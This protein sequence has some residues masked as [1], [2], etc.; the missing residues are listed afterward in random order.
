[1]YALGATLIHLLTGTS[2]ADLPQKDS[3]IQFND[4]VSLK[5]SF[6]SWIETMTEI[7]LEKRYS[8]ARQA[9]EALQ[10]GQMRPSS[11]AK[12]PTLRKFSKPSGTYIKLDKSAEQL[13]IIIPAPG[14]KILA[15]TRF[16]PLLLA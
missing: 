13:T 16:L 2:P 3:R 5:P 15:R 7:A 12:L 9:L 11:A 14:L 6:V 10:S 4:K 1:L 8:N